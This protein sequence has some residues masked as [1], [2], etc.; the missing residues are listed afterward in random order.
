MKISIKA[1]VL[2]ASLMLST[3]LSAQ[4]ENKSNEAM[5]KSASLISGT[6]VDQDDKVPI[7][8]ANV[9]LYQIKDSSLIAGTTTDEKGNFILKIPNDVNP[10]TKQTL[11]SIENKYF[12]RASFVGY[13]DQIVHLQ[14]EKQDAANRDLN[15]ALNISLKKN[16]SLLGAAVVKA[17]IPKMVVRNDAF[18]T[19]VK[20]S[21]LEKAG[22][23]NNVLQRIPMVTGSDGVFEV[24]GKGIALI[25]INRRQVHD[26]SELDN[27]SSENI[28]NVEVVTNPGARYD[29]STKAVIRI[30]TIRKSGDGFGFDLRSSYYASKYPDLTEQINMNYRINGL[31]I[32]STVKYSKNEV[33]Q[34]SKLWQTV[35]ADTIWHQNNTVYATNKSQ[36]FSTIAGI[37]Y[38]I[39]PK[40]FLGAKY[41]YSSPID[42]KGHATMGNEMFADNVLYDTWNSYMTFHNDNLPTHNINAYYNGSVGKLNI[43]YNSTFLTSKESS[44][45]LTEED[46][47]NFENRNVSSDNDVK[48]RLFASK[49]VLTYPIW[50]GN[51]SFGNEYTNTFRKDIYINP[52]N[53]VE[54]SNTKIKNQNNSF[55]IEYNFATS[56]GMFG[57]GLRYEN[58]QSD[59]YSFDKKIDEQCKDY[60]QW[61]PN[62][63]FATKVKNLGLQLSYTAKTQRP[64]YRQLSSNVT[65]ANRFTLQ[66]GNPFLDPSVI[67]DI[68]L[69]SS[70]KFLQLMLSYK[71]EHDAIIYWT[72]QL[73]NRPAISLI[74]YKNINHLPSF[75][76]YLSSSST[77]GCWTPQVSAGL[78]K[79]WFNLTSH[80]EEFKLNK[81]IAVFSF[82][83][84]F[85]FTSDWLINFDSNYRSR[86]NSQNVYLYKDQF[87]VN[88]G[89]TKSLCNNNLS[90]AVKVYDI[91][92]GAQD[93]N[94]L[95]NDMMV[96]HQGNRYDTRKVEFT[97]RYKFNSAKSKYKGRGAGSSELKRF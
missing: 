2:I 4:S 97:L 44:Y 20:N 18:V 63:S 11:T 80:G 59:Y 26:V 67:H 29:A 7:S 6:V 3:H 60:S 71:N 30:T 78:I 54:S 66:T 86:G 41:T 15:I 53:V 68:T 74:K 13:L 45:T 23:A 5:Q 87:I 35:Y 22:T 76:I 37:N 61:F 85:R 33:L 82:N 62:L 55:F 70:W 58:V 92:E 14:Q 36:N 32:F 34:D 19:T 65:Y 96:L 52:E 47:K 56:F 42:I 79:Q 38:E 46:S 50:K 12:I 9:V 81:P 88:C 28:R 39:S 75:T 27:L 94:Q 69:N 51:L 31:D 89:V 43:D 1:M 8:Y 72:E 83:N 17:R 77:F 73:E 49:L 93:N 21:V 16:A 91:F 24:F 40:H 48:N 84:S 25:Y 64:S 95:Y 90:L 10:A 57:A